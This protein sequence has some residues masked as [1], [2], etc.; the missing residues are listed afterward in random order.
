MYMPERWRQFLPELW[1][2]W[3]Y[4]KTKT[5]HLSSFSVYSF[6]FSIL[7]SSILPSSW[8]W[9][10]QIFRTRVSEPLCRSFWGP[11]SLPSIPLSSSSLS[12]SLSSSI[13]FFSSYVTRRLLVIDKKYMLKLLSVFKTLGDKFWLEAI[14]KSY[15]LPPILSFFPL[16]CLVLSILSLPPPP[17]P[18]VPAYRISR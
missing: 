14:D 1:L 8:R 12:L 15:L 18:S 3:C 13:L 9:W 17:P 4:S 5:N 2:Q 6:L 16:S 10:I 7:S 11:E